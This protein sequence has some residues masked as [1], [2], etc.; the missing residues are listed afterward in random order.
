MNNKLF[1]VPLVLWG[2]LCSVLTIVWI[3]VWPGDKATATTGL[4]FIILRWFHALVW[5]FLAIA[6]FIA[7]FNVLGGSATARRVAW[8]SLVTYLVFMAT[9]LTTR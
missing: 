5:L 7:A 8:L 1:G 4:R 6:A 9:L 2:V 3:F